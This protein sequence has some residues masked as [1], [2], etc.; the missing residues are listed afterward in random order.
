MVKGR[1]MDGI[2]KFFNRPMEGG[3]RFFNRPKIADCRPMQDG[4]NPTDGGR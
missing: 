2:Y 3:V 1:P 4:N